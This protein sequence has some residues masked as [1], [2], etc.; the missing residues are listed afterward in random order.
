M[1]NRPSPK[2]GEQVNL[3]PG[4][5]Q[6]LGNGFRHGAV[7]PNSSEWCKQPHKGFVF[8]VRLEI[9]GPNNIT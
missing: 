9:T 6:P 4:F 2:G 7:L 8:T 3:A 1:S 5:P